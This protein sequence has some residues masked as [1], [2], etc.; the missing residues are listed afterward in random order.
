MRNSMNESLVPSLAAAMGGRG[1]QYAYRIVDLRSGEACAQEEA[2]RVPSA[3]LIKLVVMGEI[4]RR[5]RE[6]SLSLSQ[7]L[8]PAEGDRVPFSILT[9]LDAG[10]SYTL[11]DVVKLMIVQS[12][13]TAANILIRL[14]GM[15]AVNEFSRGLGLRDTILQRRMMDFKA[16]EE[17]RENYTTAADMGRLLE[18]L[19][20][21]SL[22]DAEASR[23]MLEVMCGQLDRS[24][25]MLFIPDATR[26]AHKTGELDRLDH[27]AA[28]VF[29][30]KADYLFVALV[31]DAPDNNSS[32]LALGELSRITYHFFMES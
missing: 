2:L 11:V 22:V 15:E 21:G 12:D 31:W 7:R 32:R 5:V 27:E 9:L 8:T 4:M 14:A 28:V 3:S 19:Y 17:G 30:E 6:G 18:A 24:M 29:T 20:R 26:V 25:M 13:N 10:N 23:W 1:C 16:R